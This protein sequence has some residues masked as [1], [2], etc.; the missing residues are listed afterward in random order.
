MKQRSILAIGMLAVLALAACAP[1]ASPTPSPAGSP[2]QPTPP[3]DTQ[4]PAQP[5]SQATEIQN[6]PGQ[7]GP[8][9]TEAPTEIPQAVAT[10]RGPDLEST[11][12]ST[13]NL[14]SGELQ[15]VEFF[16]FT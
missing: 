16:R 10:S 11:E 6:Q 7:T 13:V 8:V 15:L 4:S 3:G 9:P 12:P 14:A 1:A 2:I 5:E